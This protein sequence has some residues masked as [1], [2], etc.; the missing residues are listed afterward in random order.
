MVCYF[1]RWLVDFGGGGLAIVVGCGCSGF[2][3]SGGGL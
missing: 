1:E 2:Q 3:S